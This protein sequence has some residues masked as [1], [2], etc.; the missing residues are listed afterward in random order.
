MKA[1]TYRRS[2]DKMHGFKRTRKN[3]N[4]NTQRLI[5]GLLLVVCPGAFA[6]LPPARLS[7]DR[8]PTGPVRI[9][10]F[11]EA[12]RDYSIET[13]EALATNGW[14]P[15][16]TF[17]LS[18]QAQRWFDPAS[19]GLPRR[20]YR[21]VTHDGPAPTEVATNFRLIDH[22]GKSRELNYH[23]TD[24]NVV[25]FVLVFAAHGCAAVR[26][27]VPAL[28][29]LRSQFESR[30][31]R[32][33][34]IDSL[35]QDSRSNIVAEAVQL[36]LTLPILH[37]RAQ[38]VARAYHTSASPEAF[39]VGRG[40][41][42]GD[43]TIVY[44]G[45]I[46]D[47]TGSA[48]NETTQPY[49][50]DA[51]GSYLADGAVP[52][53]RTPTAGCP[54]P[55]PPLPP[56]SYATDIAPLLQAKCVRCHSPGNIAPWSMTNYN[57]VRL[58]AASMREQVMNAHMP[59][60]HAD[61]EYGS[62]T[63]DFSLS[64][65]QAARLVHWIDEGALRGDGTDPLANSTPQ[66]EYPF[67]WPTELGPP[68]AILTFPMQSISATGIEPYRYPTMT[69]P[70][71]SNVWLRAAVV[72]PSNP[73]A[74]HHE[75]A[76]I[77]NS[78]DNIGG[79]NPGQA[80]WIYP[81]GTHRLLPQD[82]VVS[83][84]LHYVTSGTP[85]TDQP[86]I[87][88]Y[89]AR[90]NPPLLIQS[91]SLGW[92]DEGGG[93]YPPIL[94]YAREDV[95][96]ATY[97]FGSDVYL[98]IL[99]VHMHLRGTSMR[100][101]AIYPDGTREMLMSVPTFHAHWQTQYR[102]AR[103]K[104]LPSGTTIRITGAF[105]NSPQK[106]RNPSPGSTVNWGRQ[107]QDE[108]F[109]GGLH[110]AETL[111]LRSQ[112]QN[113]N[114]ARGST[115]SFR[116]TASSPNPPIRYQWRFNDFLLSGATN[117]TLTITN[118]QSANVGTYSVSVQDTTETL[119][120]SPAILM[121]GDPPVIT[122]TPVALTVLV[123]G[124]ATFSASVTGTPPFGF[125]WRKVSTGLTNIVQNEG[126]SSFTLTHVRTN[127]AGSYRVVVTNAFNMVPGVASPL[128]PLTVTTP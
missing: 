33:W 52:F 88:F 80:P 75:M 22:L 85:Q 55:L 121:V 94:P 87:G 24:T 7:I 123:G 74:A 115:P 43:W 12:G 112:P 86:R 124:D 116:V 71:P 84:S 65:A 99:G 114:V 51:L 68:D 101:E 78:D 125:Q 23:W 36:G 37:D 122:Q 56:V 59:P 127:D 103:P 40:E 46:D 34:M 108:M 107:L 27:F 64:P 14:L 90:D 73:R 15:L 45:A 16:A 76:Y 39:V 92:A 32:F 57:V 117:A 93:V 102:L 66:L 11:G 10:L 38:L 119:T 91:T 106:E 98:F 30:K 105:D 95:R 1:Q 89:L 111:T 41:F 31:V 61:P 81:P 18:G 13:A 113:Q 82:A 42:P 62:F 53:Q 110:F 3:M 109:L 54:A 96:T 48:T 83:I 44:R 2:S 100:H 47:R 58:Y 128:V 20:F 72:L 28:N 120:T 19:L 9:E 67:A 60:W 35:A 77:G 70:F 4:T 126:T 118:A 97:T 63:N 50:A 6:Q 5:M 104:R 21:A 17:S 29:A 8:P 69:T 25:A 26:D 49:L 79:Y